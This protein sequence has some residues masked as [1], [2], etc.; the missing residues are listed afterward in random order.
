MAIAAGPGF[1]RHHAAE[2]A[3]SVRNRMKTTKTKR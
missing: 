1:A 3:N 2:K